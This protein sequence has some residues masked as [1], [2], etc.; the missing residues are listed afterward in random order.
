[1]TEFTK[2]VLFT[3]SDGRARFRQE[4]VSLDEGTPGVLLFAEDAL[5]LAGAGENFARIAADESR[6][7][8]HVGTVDER[9][10]E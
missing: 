6:G 9:E 2:T 4:S 5:A 1:M 3:G 8:K 7:E 10:V